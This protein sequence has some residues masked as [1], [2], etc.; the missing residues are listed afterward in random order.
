[1][2]M[3]VIEDQDHHHLDFWF[4][5]KPLF[6]STHTPILITINNNISVNNNNDDPDHYDHH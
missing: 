4:Q 6:L 3:N 2:M 5:T 1:M